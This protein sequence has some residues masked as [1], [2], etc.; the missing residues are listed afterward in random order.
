MPAQI[1]GQRSKVKGQS[2]F[3]LI[4]IILAF[5]LIGVAITIFFSTIGSFLWTKGG[6]DQQL[7]TRIAIK[8]MEEIRNTPFSSLPSSG[9]FSDPDL[10]KL[11]SGSGNLTVTDWNGNSGIKAVTVKVSWQQAQGTKE[12]RLD[13]LITK[14]G[15]GQQ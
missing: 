5:F 2:G 11:P 1:R 14:G 6:K 7:A 3:S 12:V 15:I 4:E 10:S 13:T 8:K 9:P